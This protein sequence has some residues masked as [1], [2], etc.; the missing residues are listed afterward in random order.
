[1]IA[2]RATTNNPILEEWGYLFLIAFVGR[3]DYTFCNGSL[4]MR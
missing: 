2:L 4:L 1:M 3:V